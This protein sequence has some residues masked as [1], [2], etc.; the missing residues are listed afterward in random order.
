MNYKL[1]VPCHWEILS[2]VNDLIYVSTGVDDYNE[3]K[4]YY[5][6]GGIQKNSYKEEG[7][8]NYYTK[9]LRANRIV[10]KGDVLQARMKETN[11]AILINNELD[12]TL[13]STGFFQ[14][15]PNPKTYNPKF[16]Y[17]YLSSSNFL[18]KKK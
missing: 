17:Y 10:K 5:S 3:E 14:L 2:L 11:K 18:E 9:P 12:K 7:V 6:T 15:R 16:L 8:Y 4:K 1:H 13:F